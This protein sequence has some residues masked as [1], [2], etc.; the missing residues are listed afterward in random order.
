MRNGQEVGS[1]ASPIHGRPVFWRLL[2][3]QCWEDPRLDFEALRVNSGHAVLSVTSGGCNTLALATCE[4]RK[5]YAVDLNAAQNALLEL[6][7]AGIRTL[8]HAEYLEFLGARPSHRRGDLFD[9]V[10]YELSDAARCTWDARR[11][12]IERGILLAGR[13]ERF[14]GLF[15][16]LLPWLVGRRRIER[17]FEREDVEERRRFYDEEWNTRRWRLFF[18]LFF[19]RAVLGRGGLDPAFFT[20]VSGIEDFGSHFLEKARHALVD[21][22]PRENYFLSQLCFGN[23]Q[24]DGALPPYL[25]PAAY[26]GLRRA[27]ERI[28]IVTEE[29]GS[30]LRRQPDE[31]ID[32]FNYSNVFEW[33]SQS[34]FEAVLCETHRVAAPGARLCYRNLLVRRAHPRS[35]DSLFRPEPELAR[36][37][38]WEDRSFVYSGFEVA[39]VRKNGGPKR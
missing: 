2:F 39:E 1:P 4:P 30:F 31:S 34:A 32:R 38:L 35:L 26:P 6:K 5:I 11:K 9:Q 24:E 18:R 20:F 15:R 13:Y 33:V 37:L 8:E 16:R 29:L 22:S 25:D 21:L 23:Y 14:L 28:E 27:V 19:S 10:R 36:R 17:L 7:I 3:A 12:E